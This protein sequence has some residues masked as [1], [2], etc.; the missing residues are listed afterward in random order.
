MAG[1]NPQSLRGGQLYGFA[2]THS[3]GAPKRSD[4]GR[5]GEGR[6]CEPGVMGSS[7]D[8]FAEAFAVKIMLPKRKARFEKAYGFKLASI[9]TQVF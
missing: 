1:R 9:L 3:W 2:Q 4:G 8:L 5:S 6:I 7:A